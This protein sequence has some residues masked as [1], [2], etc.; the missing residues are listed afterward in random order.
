MVCLSNEGTIQATVKDT[1]ILN[2][3][4]Q[5]IV[6]LSPTK[7]V[8]NIFIEVSNQFEYEVDAFELILQNQ[9]GDTVSTFCL[10]CVLRWLF[11]IFFK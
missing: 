10:I 2:F 8:D 5:C 6:Q 3:K 4:R 7:L 1:T 11:F 9:N